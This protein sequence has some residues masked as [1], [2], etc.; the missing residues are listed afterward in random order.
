M[1]FLV[2]GVS[3]VRGQAFV[4]GKSESLKVGTQFF[5]VVLTGDV[6]GK[7]ET[8]FRVCCLFEGEGPDPGLFK[9]PSFSSL[10]QRSRV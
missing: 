8:V 1:A 5:V 2:A 7:G 3:G 6:G 10:L 4:K 9:Q